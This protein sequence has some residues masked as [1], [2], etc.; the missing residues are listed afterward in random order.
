M[1]AACVG[2]EHLSSTSQAAVVPST[3]S[4]NFPST[5]IG[6]TSAPQTIT[7][8]PA[9]G[10]ADSMDT[11]SGFT[12]SCSPDFVISP[13]P[14]PAPVSRKC[15]AG[16]G[17]AVMPS[18]KRGTV[19][20]HLEPIGATGSV[21][22]TC[23]Q[24]EVFT[25]KFDI[26]FR[27]SSPG[28]QTC[29]LFLQGTFGMLAI[30]V[31]GTG[32]PP[33]KV[34]DVQPPDIDFG[35]VR[36]PTV[37]RV[38]PVVVRN[39]GGAPLVITSV[40]VDNTVEFQ[41][42][43]TNLGS[44]S[45]PVG[46]SEIY[47]V[48]CTPSSETTFASNVRI[49]SDAANL[50]TALVPLACRGTDSAL[51][52]NPGSP[53][54]LD[55]RVGEPL[56]QAITIVNTG[57]GASNIT[58]IQIVGITDV[59]INTAPSLPFNVNPNNGSFNVVVGYPATVPQ[60]K[61]STGKLRITHDGETQ[62]IILSTSALSTALGA[63]PDAV[64]FGPVCINSM[65]SMPVKVFANAPGSFD[66]TAVGT[67]GDTMFSFTGSLGTANGG[68]ANELEYA[69]EVTPTKLGVTADLVTITTDIP[70]TPPRE[71]V[72]S[73]EGLPDGVSANP[74]LLDYG[75][76]DVGATTLFKAVK[77][78]NC[79]EAALEII[80]A[81]IDGESSVDFAI[82]GATVNGVPGPL[83][84]MLQP[85]ENEEILVVMSPQQLPGP[86]Q[87]TATLVITHSQGET[88]AA[89]DGTAVGDEVAPPIDP[90]GPETYYQCSSGGSGGWLIGFVVLGLLVRR[91]RR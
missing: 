73:V 7:I 69:A 90:K 82:V 30:G 68:H 85:T 6:Q 42:T 53:V 71:F 16:S 63:N 4:V 24:F 76:V 83:E 18:D 26:V 55:T 64:D 80:S 40:S 54:D 78:T 41:V 34:I 14:L 72:L 59:T 67:P 89:L 84:R 35:D 29:Q 17:T 49:T 3:G 58:G 48:T 52:S 31:S 56:V 28:T 60:A 87:R 37:S 46:A 19:S 33:P 70:N 43:G 51:V 10:S 27:P 32:T 36:L 23:S 22:A 2:V 9:S 79:D 65:K 74:P 13:P 1:V 77:I 66:V 21:T 47:N 88:T 5:L 20:G 50:P 25:A 15:I 86:G 8:S 11:I 44:H 57:T 39:A 62:D 61:S 81:R 91:R 12:T 75:T 45:L 38:V